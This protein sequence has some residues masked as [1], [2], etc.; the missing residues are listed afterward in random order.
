M[1]EN[2]PRVVGVLLRV[3]GRGCVFHTARIIPVIPCRILNNQAQPVSRHAVALRPN[4]KAS[5][6]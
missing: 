4:Q 3:I 5:E 2:C 1:D 6:V